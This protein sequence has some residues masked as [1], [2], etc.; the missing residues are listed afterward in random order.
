MGRHTT[1]DGKSGR[2]GT[3]GTRGKHRLLEICSPRTLSSGVRPSYTPGRIARITGALTVVG[4]LAAL[5]LPL[6]A[7]AAGLKAPVPGVKLP[8]T[9]ESPEAYIPQASCDPVAK[10]GVVAFRALMFA[11]YKRGSDGG[12][13]RACGSG[14]LSEHKEGR[15]WDWMLNARNGSDAAVATSVL[16]WLIGAGP[17]GELGWNARR[18]GIMYI[19]WNDRIWGAYRAGEGWRPYT[20]ASEHTDHIH[21]SFG[22]NGAEKHTSWW[23]GRVATMDYGPCPTVPGQL[24]APYH[25]FNPVPCGQPVPPPLVIFARSG[26]TGAHVLAVQRLLKIRPMSGFYGAVTAGRVA[27]FQKAH[28]LPVTGVVTLQTAIAMHLVAAPAKPV[29]PWA[30]PG[31]KSPHV[32]AVQRLL[33]VRPLSGFYGPVTT[34]RVRAYQKAHHLPISGVVT[35][36]TAI[37]MH[38]VAPPKPLPLPPYAKPGDHGARV[39]AVQRALHVHPLSGF[40]GAVTARAVAAWQRGHHL[41]PTGIVDH[42]TAVRMHLAH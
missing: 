4:A 26:D 42:T 10:P 1:R 23:T 38:F 32:L 15:A 35:I 25:G 3:R 36:Q 21:F 31:D 13:T 12:I 9:A 27:A 6:G 28:H 8:A 17:H 18:F 33:K 39:S 40:Y 30:K 24:A 2:R 22:W 7:G 19:I 29:P 34:A 41:R 16:N 20:G 37:S 11:T 14:G 5:S